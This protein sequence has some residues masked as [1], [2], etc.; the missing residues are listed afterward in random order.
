MRYFTDVVSK[1]RFYRHV[2]FCSV[3]CVTWWRILNC[4]KV[5]HQKFRFSRD[6]RIWNSMCLKSNAFETQVSSEWRIQN[7][8]FLTV[9]H[10]KCNV[11][12]EWRQPQRILRI[13]IDIL[14]VF[15]ILW[16]ISFFRNFIW[17]RICSI[18]FRNSLGRFPKPHP[19][20][21]SKIL[22]HWR[23]NFFFCVT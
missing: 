11:S 20:T 10:L 15:L 19:R 6:W 4:L 5:T 23:K 2:S 16:R 1:W 3:T 9:T 13:T 21:T 14:F 18:P 12:Q 22:R 7:S 17:W 8:S